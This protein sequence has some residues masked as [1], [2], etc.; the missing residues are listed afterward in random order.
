MEAVEALKLQTGM[1]AF[2]QEPVFTSSRY[3]LFYPYLNRALERQLCGLI[4][5]GGVVRSNRVSYTKL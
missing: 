1:I 4:S 3:W 5:L 2:A